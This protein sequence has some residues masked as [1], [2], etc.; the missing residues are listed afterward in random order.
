MQRL[1]NHIQNSYIKAIITYTGDKCC[2][3]GPRFSI[4]N[5]NWYL[6]ALPREQ[7]ADFLNDATGIDGGQRLIDEDVEQR[8]FNEFADVISLKNGRYVYNGPKFVGPSGYFPASYKEYKSESGKEAD[9][10]N[11]VKSK[12]SKESTKK[13]GPFLSAETYTILQHEVGVTSN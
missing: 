1:E 12:P 6:K 4:Q 5:Q 11:F 9:L 13:V 8:L 7:L 10:L 3:I 2:T